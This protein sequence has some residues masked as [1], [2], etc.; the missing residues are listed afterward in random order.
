M[1]ALLLLS[2]LG[3]L[4][5]PLE[6]K[7]ELFLSVAGDISCPKREEGPRRICQGGAVF[8]AMPEEHDAVLALGDLLQRGEPTKRTYR[9][10]FFRTWPVSPRRLYPV[11]GNHD[12]DKERGRNEGY[13]NFLTSVGIGNRKSWYSW[14]SPSWLFLALD[15]NCEWVDCSLGGPQLSWL[16]RELL[17]SEKRCVLAYFHHPLFHTPGPK[18][19]APIREGVRNIWS[20]LDAHGAD[21]VLNGHWHHYERFPAL[22]PE[23]TPGGIRQFTVGTGGVSL[24][25]TQKHPLADVYEQEFGFLSLRLR[26]SSYGWQFLNKEKDILDWGSGSCRE[27]S[28]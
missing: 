7:T 1:K 24:F 17:A 21:V 14:Q 18:Q 26:E 2:L 15:S 22:S 23:G 9:K 10:N 5:V 16:E 12:Y 19:S 3:I 11:P 25:E 27:K 20:I 13:R 4:F 8:R 28:S 6:R